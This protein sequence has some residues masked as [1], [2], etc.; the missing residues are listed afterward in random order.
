MKLY[1]VDPDEGEYAGN[2]FGTKITLYAGAFLLAL[3]LLVIGRHYYLDVPFGFDDPLAPASD[4]INTD[5]LGS[6]IDSLKT[7]E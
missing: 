4:S 2:I 6:S 5:E 7:I 3:T 1:N